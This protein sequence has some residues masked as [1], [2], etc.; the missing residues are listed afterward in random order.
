MEVELLKAQREESKLKDASLVELATQVKALRNDRNNQGQK[1][2]M[3]TSTCH[4]YEQLNQVLATEN[5]VCLALL[6][7]SRNDR[8]NVTMTSSGRNA[9]L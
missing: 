9:T 1:I 4:N 2:D 3:L 7:A 6:L 8:S 5:Q